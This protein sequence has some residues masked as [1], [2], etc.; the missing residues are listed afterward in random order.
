MVK[1]DVWSPCLL[2]FIGDID[3]NT[4]FFIVYSKQEQLPNAHDECVESL[5][6]GTLFVSSKLHETRDFASSKKSSKDRDSTLPTTV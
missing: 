6:L 3:E 4:I 5:S 2:T 1:L